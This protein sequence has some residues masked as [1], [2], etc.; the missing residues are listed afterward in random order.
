MA[1]HNTP[2]HHTHPTRQAHSELRIVRWVIVRVPLRAH[3]LLPVG[4]ALP[5]TLFRA[6]KL[7]PKLPPNY[8]KLGGNWRDKQGWPSENH[9]INQPSPSPTGMAWYVRHALQNR[10]PQ[11]NSGRGLQQNQ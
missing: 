10:L 4:S 5:C 11:F 2:P 1:T 8:S 9:L 3:T 6:P 7:P